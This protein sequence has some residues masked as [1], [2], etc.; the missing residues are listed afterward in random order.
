MR[1]F[2]SGLAMMVMSGLMVAPISAFAQH[3]HDQGNG[4]HGQR[5]QGNGQHGQPQHK[6][7]T[8]DQ[9]THRQTQVTTHRTTEVRRTVT[10]PPYQ[11]TGNPIR[12]RPQSDWNGN[13]TIQHH[14]KQDWNNQRQDRNRQSQDWNRDHNRGRPVVV[15]NY[16]QDSSWHD[17]DWYFE[18]RRNQQNEWRTLAIGAGLIGVLGLVEHD[19]TLFFAGAAGALYSVYRLNEDRHSENRELRARAYYFDHPYFVRNGVLFRRQTVERDGHK[20]YRFCRS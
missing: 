2:N 8:R 15:Q 20:Y 3:H 13:R 17:R 11:R 16:Y 1:F 7:Q 12:V 4:Q 6:Q 5:D 14:S 9:Q 18:N 10:K 19:N